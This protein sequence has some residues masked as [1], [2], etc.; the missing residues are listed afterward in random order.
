MEGVPSLLDWVP[1]SIC[2]LEVHVY[3]TYIHL[4]DFV[5]PIKEYF[6]L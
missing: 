3:N 1:V 4:L 5:R 2:R 6:N